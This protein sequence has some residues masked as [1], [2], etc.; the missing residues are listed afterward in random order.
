MATKLIALYRQPKDPVAFDK[1][2]DEV[3]TPLIRA[4]PGLKSLSVNRIGKH[5]MGP[6]RPY[7][8]AVMEFADDESFNA[9]MASDENK[10]AGKDVQS[11]AGDI[12]SLMVARD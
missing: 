8:V 6:D 11:F 1:H 7:L 12:V 2:Y 3:H 4:V 9:A 10:A 5:L